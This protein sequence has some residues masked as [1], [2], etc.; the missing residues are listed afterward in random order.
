M[1]IK[2]FY[3]KRNLLSKIKN[4]FKRLFLIFIFVQITAFQTIIYAQESKVWEY[5]VRAGTV[6]WSKLPTH[7]EKL[8]A[9][10]IPDNLLNLIF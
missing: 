9:L 10:N 3:S 2:L 1:K 8:D 4:P 6:E 7:K 5:P